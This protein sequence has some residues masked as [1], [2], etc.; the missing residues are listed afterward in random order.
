MELVNYQFSD[1]VSHA[2]EI[3]WWPDPEVQLM[4]YGSAVG[5][6]DLSGIDSTALTFVGDSVLIVRLP[7]PEI[8]QHK[9]DHQ[10]SKVLNTAYTS[11]SPD[12]RNL[13][14]EAYKVAEQEIYKAAL[15]SGI[16]ENTR[17][18][19]DEILKPSL[20]AI[21]QRKVILQFPTNVQP[22]G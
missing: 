14:D 15:E 8:C 10:N 12:K 17:K 4:D 7:E 21:S 1:Q 6:V 13:I 16:I 18:K 9:V 22:T 3:D 19:A 11:S 2:L 20:E 5:C